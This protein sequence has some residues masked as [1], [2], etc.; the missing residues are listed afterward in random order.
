MDAYPLVN[1]AGRPH[2]TEFQI[3]EI[4]GDLLVIRATNF[5]ETSPHEEENGI[6]FDPVRHADDQVEMAAILDSI[7]LSAPPQP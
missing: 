7:Q 1:E 6:P 5:P 4:D 2:S 3:F